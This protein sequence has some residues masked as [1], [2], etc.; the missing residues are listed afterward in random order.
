MIRTSASRAALLGAIVTLG[1]ATALGSGPAR[2]ATQPA[3]WFDLGIDITYAGRT[4]ASVQQYLASLPTETQR[5]IMNACEHYMV[6][7]T[8]A[9][10]LDTIP[11][12][13]VATGGGVTVQ[14]GSA[15]TKIVE[16]SAVPAP[17]PR[18]I[19]PGPRPV[20]RLYPD[21]DENGHP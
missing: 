2:A 20:F 8:S 17:A 6:Y 7:P 1:M 14:T 18:V 16:F 9:Q 19:D 12:C 21:D 15:K 4:A 11:F 3:G 13:S 10:E 5:A